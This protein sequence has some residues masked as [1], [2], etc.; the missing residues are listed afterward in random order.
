VEY[1][2]AWS[3]KESDIFG[4]VEKA[5][6]I[7]DEQGYSG[8]SYDADGLGAGVRGDARVL[9]AKRPSNQLEVVA[10]RGSGAVVDPEEPIPSAA[11]DEQDRDDPRKN[12]D[13]FGNAKA[14]AWWDLRV[15]FLRTYRAVTQGA[16]FNPD[17]IISISSKIPK[18]AKLTAELS[19]PTYKLN[20]AGKIIVNKAPEGTKS[21][22]LA[23]SVMIRFARAEKIPRGFFDL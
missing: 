4:T 8:F 2:D 14:Q 20:G 6:E 7:T 9:N 12:E 11:S 3:G 16:A 5:F 13:Y 1:V 10:F 19:Q 15:R 23:D 18:L 21:P 22:N 17:E